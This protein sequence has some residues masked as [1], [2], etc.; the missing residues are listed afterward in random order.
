MWCVPPP[1]RASAKSHDTERSLS[2]TVTAKSE[3]SLPSGRFP[4]QRSAQLVRVPCE[5]SSPTTPPPFK[6]FAL[7]KGGPVFYQRLAARAM[8][9]ALTVNGCIIDWGKA[10]GH[11][12]PA[13]I[14]ILF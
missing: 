2:S 12:I 8:P 11:L 3:D 14:D 4:Q 13:F 5:L 7:P 9:D 10:Q 1:V 6:L